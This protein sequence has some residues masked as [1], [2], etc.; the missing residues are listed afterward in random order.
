M[1]GDADL[2]P[3]R[4][5]DAANGRQSMTACTLPLNAT[6]GSCD[7]ARGYLCLGLQHAAPSCWIVAHTPVATQTLHLAMRRALE[8]ACASATRTRTPVHHTRQDFWV[9]ALVTPEEETHK[10]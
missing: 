8:P 9:E 6:Q 3:V 7:R 1:A 4:R 5:T 2:R 10:P